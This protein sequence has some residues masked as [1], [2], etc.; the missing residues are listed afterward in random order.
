MY[1]LHDLQR[2]RDKHNQPVATNEKERNFVFL[3]Q[4]QS[5]TQSKIF[6][7]RCLVVTDGML[8]MFDPEPVRNH[9]ELQHFARLVAWAS[10]L[11]ISKM[12]RN[13][14]VPEALAIVF[15]EKA[16]KQPWI[17][18]LLAKEHEIL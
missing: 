5:E 3:V 8:L 2:V 6:H 14:K 4:E 9:P 16:D 15:K 10:L 17:L 13:P 7:S 1:D 12:R 11:S 18:C